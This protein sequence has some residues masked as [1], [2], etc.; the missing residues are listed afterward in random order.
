[1]SGPSGRV[2]VVGI[3]NALVDVLSHE[4]DEFLVTHGLVKGS[5]ALVDTER[6]ETLYGAMGPAVE[7]S[8]GSAANTMAGLASLGSRVAFI[9][10]VFADQLGE[11]Y[12]H[13]LRAAGVRFDTPPATAGSPSGRCLI[14]VTPDAERTMNTYLGASAELGASDVDPDL[15]AAA[16]VT[17]LEGY[18]WDAP[19][20]QEAFRFAAEQAHAAGRRVSLTLSDAMAVERHR[21]TFLEL[22]DGAVDILFANE[23]EI[24]TLYQVDSFDAAL[25]RVTGHCEVAALTRSA[26]GSVIVRG[27]EVHVVDAHPVPGG[28]VVDTTGAGDSYAAGFLHGFTEGYDLGLCGRLGALAASEV[29]SHLGPRPETNLAELAAPLISA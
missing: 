23:A 21:D 19:G 7:I 1:M 20:A 26:K 13:D 6:A 16:E 2:A 25:Q 15:I 3:G 10:R 29:I 4:P 24:T 12:T 28:R 9:G 27:E 17:F 22:I 14:V 5:M 8:G 18:L 11:V